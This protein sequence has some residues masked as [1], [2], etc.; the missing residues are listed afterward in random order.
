V[1]FHAAAYKHVPMLE[2]NP[3]EA[4]FNNITG[5]RVIMEMAQK[6]QAERF[7]LVSTD[8]AVRPANVM[9]AS[10]RVTELLHRLFRTAARASWQSDSAMWSGPRDR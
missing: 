7:V 4:V 3:W 8:K 6:H 10:K 5:S 1:V 9:G 2:K